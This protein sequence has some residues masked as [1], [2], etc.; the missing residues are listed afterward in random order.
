MGG[1]VAQQ[2]VLDHPLLVKGIVIIDS[3]ASF[4]DNP[5]I[6]E[7]FQAVLKLEG[8]IKKEYMD[9]FQKSTLAKPIDPVYYDTLVAEGLKVP[10]RVFKAAFK[11]LMEVDYTYELKKI[12]RPVLIFWGDKDAICFRNDQ[13]IFIKEINN[14]KLLVYEGRGHALH[15]EEPQ[16]FANDLVAFVNSI[17]K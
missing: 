10:A 12:D 16:R 7:F 14:A 8:A 2:F 1:V 11:G 9:E 4:K 6:P 5:G 3:D 15:W 13:E 17:N